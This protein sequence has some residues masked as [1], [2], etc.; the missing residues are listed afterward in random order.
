MRCCAH[1]VVALQVKVH[2]RQYEAMQLEPHFDGDLKFRQYELDPVTGALT[3]DDS[4][5]L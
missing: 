2:L 3:F 5:S 1:A 4:S